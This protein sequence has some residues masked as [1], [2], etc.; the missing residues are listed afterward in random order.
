MENHNGHFEWIP[1]GSPSQRLQILISHEPTRSKS[2]DAYTVKYA[3]MDFF[4]WAC[5]VDDASVWDKEFKND[6]WHVL[7]FLE[8]TGSNGITQNPEKFH[9]GRQELEFIGFFLRE[10]GFAPAPA[11]VK[12]IQEFPRP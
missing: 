1:L 5:Q 3:K 7:E 8:L 11:I 4:R 9:F 10:D 6:I 2:G 12:L